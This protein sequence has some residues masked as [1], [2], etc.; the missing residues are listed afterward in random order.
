MCKFHREWAANSG[1]FYNSCSLK[2]AL[3]SGAS[4]HFGNS[5]SQN[6]NW[7]AVLF[8]V[9]CVLNLLLEYLPIKPDYSK[10]YG[11]DTL[12]VLLCLSGA[13]IT[14]SAPP[15]HTHL[16]L[17]GRL[18]RKTVSEIWQLSKKLGLHEAF[19]REG[20]AGGER[21][22]QYI[23]LKKLQETRQ[24]ACFVYWLEYIQGSTA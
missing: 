19:W 15:T 14:N 23:L 21:S 4:N 3:F 8:H 1:L 17:C 11:C 20:R 2:Q 22:L 16:C 12:G 5:D 6:R 18:H 13:G 24:V 7:W 10:N 9:P